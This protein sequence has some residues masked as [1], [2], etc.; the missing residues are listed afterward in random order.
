MNMPK[1]KA[2]MAAHL[3]AEHDKD[4]GDMPMADMAAMHDDMHAKGAK[5]MHAGMNSATPDREVRVAIESWPE[6]DVELRAD[7]DGMTFRGYAAVFN[8]WSEDL[9]GFRERI[10]PGAFAKSLAQKRAI[11]MFWNHNTDIALGSTRGNLTLTEDDKGLLAEAHLPDTQAGRDMSTLVRERIVDSMSFGFQTIR[12]EW[13]GLDSDRAERTLLE[14][15]LFE[16]SP[17]TGWPAYPKTSASVRELA[18]VIGEDPDE[19]AAAFGVLRDP[20]ARLTRAQAS[21]LTS[22]I[23]ARSDAPVKAV[24]SGRDAEAYAAFRAA[25]T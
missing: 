11:K 15:R 13:S 8:S 6:D 9:G 21:L 7:G 19:L 23:N 10:Q 14:V 18:G 1:T 16:V 3:K 22:L 12:D 4:P 25:L 20:A 17:V 24:F 2:A 5:H